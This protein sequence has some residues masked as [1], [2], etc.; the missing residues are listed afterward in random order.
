MLD[1][2]FKLSERK[3][4]IK[5]EVIGGVTTFLT[6]A[7]I[8]FLHPNML[9]E[10][11][12]DK[13]ALITIT[14]LASFI[15]TIIAGL[16]ANVPFALAPGLGLN[17]FFTYSIVIGMGVEWQTALGIVFISGILFLILTFSG[18]R[19]KI[20][21][22][23]PLS[24]RL[25]VPSGI[26]L[27][28]TFVGLKNMGLITSNSTT[29]I[30]MGPITPTLIL[31]L[32]GLFL[33]VLLELKKIKA[34][35]LLG[36]FFIVICGIL[37][38]QIQTPVSYI[39]A[40]PSIAPIAFKLNIFKA[41]SISLIGAIFSF[42]FV[43]LFDSVGTIIACSYEAGLVNSEGKISKID[44][45]LGSDAISTVIGSILGTSTITTYVESASGIS[46]GART[47]LSSIITGLLF[48]MAPFFS[49]LI[50]IVPGYATAPALIIVGLYM[51]R[52]IQKIIFTS[53]GE[54]IPAFLT[55]I[56]MPFTG[57]IS[58][59]LTFGFLSYI[60]V[61]LIM[62]KVKDISIVLWAIGF[63]S[64]INLIIGA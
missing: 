21:H 9:A 56:V 30:Q 42:L 37:L 1:Q 4:S 3:S 63:L 15:G 23:I 2:F 19:E 5:Q 38:G 46:A 14:C 13:N 22:S 61:K 16:W 50:H 12:M 7:Y 17:S 41:L 49:P 28:I 55:I 59:G 35:I 47:G 43:D 40:P 31:S 36:I 10:T 24:L 57:S 11:G 29:L 6:M 39:S 64:L 52:T 8:I 45:I 51:F 32:T 20:V 34:S 58:M 54:S 53:L 25:A 18:F 60:F 27:L 48:L 33:I 44:K 62:G 26:G